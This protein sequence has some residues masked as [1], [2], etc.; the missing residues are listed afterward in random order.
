M[1]KKDYLDV[2]EK[3][4]IQTEDLSYRYD[5]GE[6]LIKIVFGDDSQLVIYTLHD[7]MYLWSG[8]G[9]EG[10]YGYELK[11]I[12]IEFFEQLIIL[13]SKSSQFEEAAHG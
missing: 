4:A 5:E 11:I 12:S 9:D 2:L 8:L 10:S 7:Y 13:L 3:L 1:D 6:N